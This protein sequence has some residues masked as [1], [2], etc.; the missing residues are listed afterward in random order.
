[1]NYWSRVFNSNLKW[2]G[3]V[4]KALDGA[5]AAGYPLLLWNDRIHIVKTGEVTQYWRNSKT[6]VLEV[7]GDVRRWAGDNMQIRYLTIAELEGTE[8]A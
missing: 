2:W 1:M 3:S 4:R 6:N 5:E 7:D 8:E